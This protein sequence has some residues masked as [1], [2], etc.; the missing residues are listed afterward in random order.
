MSPFICET[1]VIKNDLSLGSV[2][3]NS[4]LK[5]V[6]GKRSSNIVAE[7][8]SAVTGGVLVYRALNPGLGILEV[9]RVLFYPEENPAVADLNFNHG[10]VHHLP[11]QAV[12]GIFL[13]AAVSSSSQFYAVVEEVDWRTAFLVRVSIWAV[14]YKVA[15]LGVFK[16]SST[17]LALVSALAS[18]AGGGV[19]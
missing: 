11:V 18:G 17:V 5:G 13:P 14:L 10:L 7:L 19:G 15:A 1:Q 2:R 4:R 8:Q 9:V 16:T 6:V 3:I 12:P